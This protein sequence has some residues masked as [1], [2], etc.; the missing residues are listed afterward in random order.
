[1]RAI[2]KIFSSARELT[3]YLNVAGI[4][5]DQIVTVIYKEGEFV[6]IYYAK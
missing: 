3:D 6:L 4:T 2:H 1:M 5:K